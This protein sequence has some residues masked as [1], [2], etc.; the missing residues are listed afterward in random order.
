MTALVFL[1]IGG[2]IVTGGSDSKA[3]KWAGAAMVVAASI[4]VAL[5]ATGVLEVAS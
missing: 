1:I 4:G 2:V 5:L 3:G